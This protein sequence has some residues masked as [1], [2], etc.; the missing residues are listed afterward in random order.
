MIKQFFLIL[1]GLTLA[2]GSTDSLFDQA[3][4]LYDAEQFDSAATLYSETLRR[5]GESSVLLYNLGNCAYRMNR[6]GESILYTERA[7]RLAP[8][9]RDIRANLDYLRTQITDELPATESNPIVSGVRSLHELFTLKEQ[10]IIFL[11]LSILIPITVALALFKSGAVR[12]WSIY[13][14][15][16][17]GVLLLLI[18]LSAGLKIHHLETVSEAIILADQVEARSE[19]S[20]GELIFTVHE[21][22]KVRII[23][24]EG[25]WVQI[26]LPNGASG[27]VRDSEIGAI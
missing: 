27:Y 19:P 11:L 24:S 18:G 15:G 16:T 14:T 8:R 12:I 5:H 1:T 26:A 9:D 13:G 25:P 3:N 23:S 10:L 7:A 2:F 22:T 20:G 17:V 21:G 4:K 6:L